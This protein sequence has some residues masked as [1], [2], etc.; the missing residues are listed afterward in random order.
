MK[1]STQLPDESAT[2]AFAGLTWRRRSRIYGRTF[3]PR[4]QTTLID[5]FGVCI[6]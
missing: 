1:F 2:M 6:S 4:T 5:V 3:L